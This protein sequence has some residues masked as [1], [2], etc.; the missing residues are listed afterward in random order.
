MNSLEYGERKLTSDLVS[1]LIYYG[2]WLGNDEKIICP[3]GNKINSLWNHRITSSQYLL[4]HWMFFTTL[5]H[6][7]W[8]ITG[9]FWQVCILGGIFAWLSNNKHWAQYTVHRPP[10]YL[11]RI[12]PILQWIFFPSLKYQVPKSQFRNP[13]HWIRVVKNVILKWTKM[14][15]SQVSISLIHSSGCS[16]STRPETGNVYLCKL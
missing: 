11:H 1:P 15:F 3:K 7:K 4:E 10:I 6:P 12:F 8:A 13:F 9:I 2:M 16:E 14:T 5:F